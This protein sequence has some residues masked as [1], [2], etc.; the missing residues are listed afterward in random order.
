MNNR[1]AISDMV[2]A[3]PRRQHVPRFKLEALDWFADCMDAILN[4]DAN[5]PQNWND[6]ERLA[7]LGGATCDPDG[8]RAYLEAAGLKL[9]KG[10]IKPNETEPEEWR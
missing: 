8:F 9:E 7:S 6:M 2:L 4:G 10:K 5:Y 3:D 1:E